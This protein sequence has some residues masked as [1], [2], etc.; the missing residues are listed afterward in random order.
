MTVALD[1]YGQHPK[2][3]YHITTLNIVLSVIWY[4]MSMQ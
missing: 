3:N 1:M 4:F 2:R